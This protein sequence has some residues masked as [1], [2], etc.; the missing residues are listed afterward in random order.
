[1]IDVLWWLACKLHFAVVLVYVPNLP[2]VQV[3][4]TVEAAMAWVR[5]NAERCHAYETPGNSRCIVIADAAHEFYNAGD[6]CR[7]R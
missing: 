5:A 4:P 1:M 2:Y 3:Y 6:Q 7:F